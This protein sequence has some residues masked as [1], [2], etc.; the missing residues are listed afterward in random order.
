MF[1]VPALLGAVALAVLARRRRSALLAPVTLV[2]SVAALAATA[3]WIADPDPAGRS[4]SELV[5]TAELMV[6]TGLVCRWSPRGW[7]MAV[8]PLAVVAGA[9]LIVPITNDPPRWGWDALAELAFWSLPGL[10]GAASGWYLR[11]LDKRRADAV[12]T[13]RRA[14][15]VQL[16]ADLHDYVAHDVSAMVVQAQAARVLLGE[17]S[18]DVA[19]VLA[20]IED[21]G[22]R[23]LESM[24][25]SIRVL[26]ESENGGAPGLEP[27]PGLVDV[28]EL[29]RRF[30]DACGDKRVRLTMEPGLDT[31][32]RGEAGNALYRVV[33]EALTNV[34]KHAGSGADVTVDL[35]KNAHAVTVTV[36]NATTR[37]RTNAATTSGLGLIGLS[38]RIETFGGAFSAGPTGE[39]WRVTAE[40]PNGS[41]E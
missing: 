2:V 29:V 6:L 19:A 25:R 22:T 16:A 5:L 26:R 36:E 1:A 4:V 15:R 18:A 27:L 8:A 31:A 38:E 12:R 33:L 39:R 9:G 40:L 13:A 21:D 30:A 7:A 41:V 11:G 14:Q 10:V 3:A 20:R 17:K 23:A 37:R 35:T 34:R 32:L 24:Q 28:P